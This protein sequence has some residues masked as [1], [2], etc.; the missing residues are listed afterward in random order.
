[1]HERVSL[2]AATG[3]IAMIALDDSA[4]HVWLL[5]LAGSDNDSLL[6]GD[7]LDE[8]ERSRAERYR[9]P[10]AR[11]SFVRTRGRLRTLLAQYLGGDPRQFAFTANEHGKPRLR[12]T[13]ED[14]GLVFNISH[15]GDFALL[16]FARDTA[17]G[18]DIELPR[19]R[20]NLRGLAD[21]CLAPAELERW[22]GCGLERQLNE[23]VRLW[24]CKEAF[25]KAV[26]RG[27]GLG[28]RK[29][30]VS[31]GFKGFEHVPDPYG[32]TE[33]WR[34][35]EWACGACRAAVAYKGPERRITVFG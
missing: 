11:N 13:P 2:P 8:D 34:L 35:H 26:G 1:M 7:C 33:E 16:A 9:S 14:C 27:I 24:V 6:A 4:I 3:D 29:V 18:V 30:G 19:R 17:L 23:F 21:A 10:K 15:S 20:M 22:H 5:D 32:P 12:D 28:L 25:V 31:R